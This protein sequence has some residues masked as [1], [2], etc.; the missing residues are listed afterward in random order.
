MVSNPMISGLGQGPSDH[1][2]TTNSRATRRKRADRWVVE[3]LEAVALNWQVSS[4][5]MPSL[6]LGVAGR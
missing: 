4:V 6:T 5:S 1:I 3:L 2:K